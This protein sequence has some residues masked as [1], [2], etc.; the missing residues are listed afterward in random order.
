MARL[1]PLGRHKSAA[2]FALFAL[3]AVLLY[4]TAEGERRIRVLTRPLQVAAAAARQPPA[5]VA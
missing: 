2:L 5:V 3:Q 4:L 1:P